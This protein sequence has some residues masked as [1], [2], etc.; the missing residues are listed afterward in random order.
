MRDDLVVNSFETS[1]FNF[2]NDNLEKL[3]DKKYAGGERLARRWGL[4]L[5]GGVV[6]A[7]MI[8]ANW[9]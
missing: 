9:V 2:S 3:S 4:A 6:G 1:A 5:C 7:T 8:S